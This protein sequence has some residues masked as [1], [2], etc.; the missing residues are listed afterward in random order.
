MT[1]HMASIIK[2]TVHGHA[3]YYARECR[4][5]DGKPKIV[6]QKYLGRAEDLITAVTRPQTAAPTQPREASVTEFGASAALFD[7]ACRLRLVEY[8][9]QHVPKARAAGPSV[10]TYLLVA[11]LNRCLAPRSKAQIGDWFAGTALRRLVPVRASQLTSQRY[12]DNMDRVTPQAIVAIERD[13][14]AHL[15]QAFH[16]DVR[17]VLFD[18]TNFFT[19]IDTFNERCTLAQRGKS[20]EGRASLRIIG[21]ALL[22]AADGHVPL[23]HHTYPG[24]QPDAPTFAGL[25]DEL[26]A[27]HQLVAAGVERVTL[28]FDKGN[29][30]EDNLRALADTPYHFIGSLVPTQ[31]PD[32]LAVPARRF[33]SL[34]EAGF[35]LV[36]AYRTQKEVFGQERTVVVT[37]NE[38]LFVAQSR[39]L[40]REIAKRQQR[41][42]ALQTQLHRWH[43]GAVHG[44]KP[45][46]VAGTQ[47]KV[48]G[49]LAARHLKDLFAVT[50]A[51]GAQG[52]P[53]LTYRFRQKAWGRLQRTLLGKT[54]LFTDNDDW[55]DAAIVRGYRGQH[56]VET[57]F[58]NLKNP[59]YLALRPQ[60]HWTDQKIKVH[61]FCCV[62]ALTLCS[63]LRREL[64]GRGMD[65]SI[66]AL[67]AELSQIREVAV[68]YPPTESS[69]LPTIRT[70]LS[71]LSDS[72]QAL[73]KA[74]DLQRYRDP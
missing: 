20:K 72:Q 60:H 41:L 26:V 14:T 55:T 48:A 45:P 56:H 54:I 22:V 63:L 69:G 64:C 47:K 73:Y 53:T 61:V 29:N 6:W 2:K 70:T 8:I 58:R 66:P 1:Y 59:H 25:T 12:W 42:Q 67:L 65:H 57:A 15:V 49:W 16:L 52:L 71:Q 9:D 50:V 7:L 31:H 5:V 68:I 36:S 44:G 28:V 10:G 11:A 19:F 13:L 46:T 18:A 43:Q 74:L 33:R 34:A 51:A 39:T 38:A 21:L 30:S 40:L 4:R 62:L 32:L 17:Q 23:C 24:N 3:Y 35:P 37:Y 27:R